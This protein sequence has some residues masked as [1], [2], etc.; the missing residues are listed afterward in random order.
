MSA[1][2]KT[3]CPSNLF[4]I[5]CKK[6][7]DDVAVSNKNHYLCI[8]TKNLILYCMDFRQRSKSKLLSVCYNLHPGQLLKDKKNSRTGL[9]GILIN[10]I[11]KPRNALLTDGGPY[12]LGGMDYKSRQALKSYLTEFHHIISAAP[13]ARTSRRMARTSFLE[14]LV[15]LYN[16]Q[17]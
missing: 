9:I 10:Y 7:G 8:R 17:Q 13:I 3:A 12:S 4:D 2:Y 15:I 1:S 6:D 5:V 14:V 11:L 16:N